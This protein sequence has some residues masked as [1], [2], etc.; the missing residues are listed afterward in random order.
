MQVKAA[1]GAHIYRVESMSEVAAIQSFDRNG[2][3]GIDCHAA[4]ACGLI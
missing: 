3:C 4:E 2:R 1:R